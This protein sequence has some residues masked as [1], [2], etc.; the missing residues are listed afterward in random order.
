MQALSTWLICTMLSIKQGKIKTISCLKLSKKK[1][2]NRSKLLDKCLILYF[3]FKGEVRFYIFLKLVYFHSSSPIKHFC[4][5]SL[6]F[7]LLVI[8]QSHAKDQSF[9]LKKTTPLKENISF[10]IND[11]NTWKENLSKKKEKLELPQRAVLVKQNKKNGSLVRCLWLY[12]QV[13][14]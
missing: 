1:L 5:N 2:K 14:S 11:V 9:C 10:N 6:L 4:E 8:S 13:E 12:Q 7:Q 3:L